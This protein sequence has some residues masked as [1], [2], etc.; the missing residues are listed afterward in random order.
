MPAKRVDLSKWVLEVPINYDSFAIVEETE[1]YEEMAEVHR[2]EV[3]SQM[4]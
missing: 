1:E 3:L 2:Y 4:R